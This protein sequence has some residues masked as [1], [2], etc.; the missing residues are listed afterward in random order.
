MP[1]Q[2]SRA[3]F[4][5]KVKAQYPVY[6]SVPDDQ[7]VDR[8]LEKYPVYRDR[9]RQ[10]TAPPA[11]TMAARPS[12]GPKPTNAAEA[13]Q[14]LADVEQ[15]ERDRTRA[16]REM[17]PS[18][19]GFAG[20]MVGGVPGA[21]LGGAA[22]EA[23][24]Q[25]DRRVAGES[26]PTTSVDAA[27]RIAAEGVVQG[28]V[29]GAGQLGAKALAT[30]GR[31]LMNRALNPSNRLAREFPDMSQT[32]I[33]NAIT[34]SKGGLSKARGLLMKAKGE[35]NA[36]IQGASK[37]GATVSINDA[38]R[39]LDSVL[40]DIANG[41]DPEG[42]LRALVAVERKLTSGRK[43]TL[44][45]EEADRLKRSLQ[46]EAQTLYRAMQSGQGRPRS[47]VQ[48]QAL[49]A[50]AK[51]LNEAIEQAAT[52]AGF[53]G[54]KSANHAAQEFLGVVR[55]IDHARRTGANLYQ[56]LVRPGIGAVLG[57]TGA[58]TQ[59]QSPVVGAVAGAAALS[60]AGMSRLAVLM[61]NPATA[62]IA[63]QSP[64]VMEMLVRQLTQEA[65]VDRS[66]EGRQEAR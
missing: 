35:A 56:A 53:P 7:L 2:L 46:T 11:T 52:K 27:K 26:A 4:A 6:A 9:I 65:A 42:G 29:E 17:L 44:T 50:A 18:L 10:D 34:V 25:L 32:A 23:V 5:Q 38:V 28:A 63:R 66:R 49:A 45:L 20:A 61:G 31:W 41:A 59:G 3:E 54:Y 57:T 30:S 58:Y 22:G 51:S 62:R 64:R 8:M 37:A 21:A 55:G 12:D 16:G 15:Y 47:N 39:G 36:A 43:G 40:D 19:A 1:Q 14:A 24:R 13:R 60:P 48:V 33:D